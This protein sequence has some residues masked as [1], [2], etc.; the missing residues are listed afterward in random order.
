MPVHRIIVI[1][2]ISTISPAFLSSCTSSSIKHEYVERENWYHRRPGGGHGH[3]HRKRTLSKFSRVK[4]E[5]ADSGKPS[6]KVAGVKISV[7]SVS[8][9]SSLWLPRFLR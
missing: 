7:G 2:L 6:E 1:L 3:Y 4:D 8:R 5:N 9:R